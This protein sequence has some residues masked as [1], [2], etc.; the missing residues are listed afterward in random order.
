MDARLVVEPRW[1]GDCTFVLALPAGSPPQ[2]GREDHATPPAHARLAAQTI[3]VV[4]TRADIR[5]AIAAS[6][7]R[8]GIKVAQFATSDAVAAALAE[9]CGPR[10]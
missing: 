10:R 4:E 9:V 8:R 2:P 5:Q 6:L 3:L 7:A 1:R